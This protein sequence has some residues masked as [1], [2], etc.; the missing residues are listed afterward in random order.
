M[1]LIPN[2]I[3][4]KKV[5]NSNLWE[6]F[7]IVI[8]DHYK[9]QKY[10]NNSM[11]EISEDWYG[12]NKN[13]SSSIR[14]EW[15]DKN[16]KENDF[17]RTLRSIVIKFSRTDYTTYFYINVKTG[18]INVFAHYTDQTG[19]NN[20]VFYLRSVDICNWMLENNLIKISLT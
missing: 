9:E 12:V 20:P 2:N 13:G 15:N 17:K 16:Y 5:K 19:R 10:Q 18:N 4:L 7:A 11:I 1:K 3:T 8:W 14:I 6:L